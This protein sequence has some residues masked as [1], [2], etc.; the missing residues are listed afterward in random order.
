MKPSMICDLTS[1]TIANQSVMD[2]F[3]KGSQPSASK[4]IW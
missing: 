2:E 3:R 4:V 1:T